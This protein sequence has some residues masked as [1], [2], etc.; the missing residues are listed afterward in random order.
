M[1]RLARFWRDAWGFARQTAG[2]PRRVRALLAENATL[3]QRLREQTDQAQAARV[4]AAQARQEAEAAHRAR[5][6]FLA[7]ACHDLR[8]PLHAA[9]LFLGSLARSGLSPRQLGLLD[10][11]QASTTAASDMLNTLLDF[12]KVDAGVIQPQPVAFALQSLFHKLDQE[13]APWAAQKGLSLRVR[14]TRVTLYADPG[15]VE[16]ILRN[17]LLNAIRYTAQG[18]VLLGCRRRGGRAVIEVWDTGIGIDPAEHRAIFREFHQL[19]G[20]QGDHRQGL[21]LG[22]AIVDGL[23]QAMGAPVGLASTPGRGS[24]FRVSLPFGQLPPEPSRPALGGADLQG[25]RVLLIDDDESVRLAMSD[26][27]GLWG[28]QCQ[29]AASTDEALRALDT[30][31]PDVVLADYRLRRAGTGLDGV[32]AI[33]ARLGW[34]VPA[35]LVTG[36]TAAERLDEA[37]DQGLALL[38]KPVAAPRLLALLQT[39]RAAGAQRSA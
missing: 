35:A 26:L 13:L 2:A 27:M 28:V 5:T 12:S 3:M 34:A 39:L 24:V 33:R 16:L 29:G 1:T 37:R 25:L 30:F 21:G 7:S 15:L 38:H 14:D 8:Q 19:G 9:G 17:L 22:L 36:D 31:Q 10:Q 20:A 18:G 32:A 23:A 6:V 11:A 4:Q